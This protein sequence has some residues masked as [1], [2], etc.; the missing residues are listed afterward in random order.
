MSIHRSRFV[1]QVP[2]SDSLNLA[3]ALNKAFITVN[4]PACKCSTTPF[5][6]THEHVVS[7][8]DAC[9]TQPI[10]FEIDSHLPVQDA[11]EQ[12]LI[13]E[14]FALAVFRSTLAGN[15]FAMECLVTAFMARD[16]TLTYIAQP[17]SLAKIKAS[18]ARASA[19]PRTWI[20]DI[21]STPSLS[22]LMHGYADDLIARGIPCHG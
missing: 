8:I 17:S 9:D 19:Q 14:T 18:A 5:N 2:V 1:V 11:I 21:L 16:V 12:S 13:S 20:E 10:Y 3:S 22:H 4:F 6:G 7:P 15:R